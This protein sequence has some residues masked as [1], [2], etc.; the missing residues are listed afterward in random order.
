MVCCLVLCGGVSGIG[1]S[2]LVFC[3]GVSG[4]GVSRPSYGSVVLLGGVGSI[5][6]VAVGGGGSG[7]PATTVPY[8][9]LFCVSAS[10]GR[11]VLLL[12]SR[13]LVGHSVCSTLFLTSVCDVGR[14]TWRLGAGGAGLS[15]WRGGVWI[16]VFP[17]FPIVGS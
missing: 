8:F 4:I 9:S 16:I 5:T 1:V 3:S 2:C 12:V 17:A 14:P 13:A 6:G 15:R 11:E 10:S 7:V